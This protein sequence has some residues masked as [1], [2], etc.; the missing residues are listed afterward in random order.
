MNRQR[1]LGRVRAVGLVVLLA[2]A[3]LL[4]SLVLSQASGYG[5]EPGFIHFYVALW[6]VS[7]QLIVLGAVLLALGW[8]LR[9]FLVEGA[10]DTGPGFARDVQR[11]PERGV[12]R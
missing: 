3:A 6:P 11:G 8:A 2:G 10:G 7:L 4:L 9:G 1:G 5:P 12:D